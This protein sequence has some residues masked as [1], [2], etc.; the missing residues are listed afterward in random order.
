M[1]RGHDPWRY[2]LYRRYDRRYMH[3]RKSAL[4]FQAARRTS[5][6]NTYYYSY[7]ELLKIEN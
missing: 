3:Q 7:R 5:L 6:V 2:Y 4:R 1:R